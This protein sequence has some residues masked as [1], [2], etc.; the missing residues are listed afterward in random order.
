M[1]TAK[2][3]N[4]ETFSINKISSLINKTD[5]E[6]Q[7]I[8]REIKRQIKKLETKNNYLSQL[9]QALN[10]N[11]SMPLDSIPICQEIRAK[12]AKLTLK[13]QK[14]IADDVENLINNC[15]NDEL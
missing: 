3:N 12:F 8:N 7:A 14:Q 6:I 4:I 13:Q 1:T 2:A 9:K 10:D 11:K 5:K 15:N